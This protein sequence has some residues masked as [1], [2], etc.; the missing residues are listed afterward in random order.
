[1]GGKLP[2]TTWQEGIGIREYC[3]APPVDPAG[4]LD[5]S[6]LSRESD[7]ICTVK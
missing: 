4:T 6:E 7:V 1:M 5:Y 2:E 3:V